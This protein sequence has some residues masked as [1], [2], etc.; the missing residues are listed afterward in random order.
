MAVN[1]A[2]QLTFCPIGVA[3]YNHQIKRVLALITHSGLCAEV[4]AMSTIIRGESA[5]VLRLIE[6]IVQMQAQDGLR[7]TMNLAISNTCG[8]T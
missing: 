3:D 1:I 8:C 2:C 6:Q 5:E 4:G 7:Y